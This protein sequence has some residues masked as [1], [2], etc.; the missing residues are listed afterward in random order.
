[1]Q[2]KP[3]GRQKEHNGCQGAPTDPSAPVGIDWQEDSR[4]S[5]LAPVG[6][7]VLWPTMAAI[8][9]AWTANHGWPL[10]AS[11]SDNWQFPAAAV[12][13]QNWFAKSI[14]QP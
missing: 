7:V 14:G 11:G 5:S 13:S 1:M 8:A 4:G 2:Y 10:A 9:V 12:A 3:K 6:F